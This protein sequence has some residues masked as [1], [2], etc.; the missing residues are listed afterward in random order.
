MKIR[1]GILCMIMMAVQFFVTENN[2]ENPIVQTN[3]TADPAP[4]VYNDTFW[5]YTGH[6]EDGSTIW[7][8]MREWR[9]YSSVDMANWTDHGVPMDLSTFSWANADAWA[10]QCIPYEGK[11]Y[12]YVPVFH[13]GTKNRMIGVAVADNPTGPFKDALGKPMLSRY[14][15]CYIDPTAFVDTDGQAYMYWGNPYCYYVKLNKDMVSYSGDVVQN[16]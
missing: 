4:M 6:D 8:N 11:F 16:S 14:D 5:M 10:G 13:T 1:T 12:F 3:Y 15:C 9:C 7:F 2:A